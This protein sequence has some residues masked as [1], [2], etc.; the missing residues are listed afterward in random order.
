MRCERL[1]AVYLVRRGLPALPK[2]PAGASSATTR[3]IGHSSIGRLGL[4]PFLSDNESTP[5]DTGKASE[6]DAALLPAAAEEEEE[7]ALNSGEFSRSKLS[8]KCSPKSAALMTFRT[9]Y[10][11]KRKI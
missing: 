8:S 2:A 5:E 4:L 11:Y 10:Q 9:Q 3:K 1:T 7:V 6:A